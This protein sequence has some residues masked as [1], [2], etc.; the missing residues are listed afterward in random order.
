M[1]QGGVKVALPAARGKGRGAKLP[2][3]GKFLELRA[4]ALVGKK[5]V[6]RNIRHLW[7]F[8]FV[9]ANSGAGAEHS[10]VMDAVCSL[11]VDLLA[12]CLAVRK[13]VLIN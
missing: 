11:G 9:T 2:D 3:A 8:F 12:V 5:L 6:R 1:K 10:H 7:S 13:K 4:P